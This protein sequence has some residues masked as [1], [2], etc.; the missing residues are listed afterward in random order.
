MSFL[1]L[2]SFD[3]Y[4]SLASKYEGAGASC[5]IV[6]GFA[7][8]GL[9][10]VNIQGGFNFLKVVRQTQDVLVATMYNANGSSGACC[11]LGNEGNSDPQGVC[12]N[13]DINGDGSISAKRGTSAGNLLLGTSA[14]GVYKFGVYNSVALR[15]TIGVAARVRIYCNGVLV[16]D[17]NGVTTVNNHNP[18][19]T[20]ID[21]VSWDGGLVTVF[22][23]DVYAL[24]CTDAIH[25]TYLGALRMYYGVPTADAAVQF[26]PSI[27]PP[28]YQQVNEVP[29]N[30]NTIFNS[31]DTVGQADQYV[32][33]F[34]GSIPPVSTLFCVQHCL[35]MEVA[36]GSRQVTSDIGG[37]LNANPVAL[38]G[39]YKIDAFQYDLNPVTGLA[40]TA[41]DFPV[42]AG[43]AVTG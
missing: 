23:D 16:L 20:Y 33:P 37:V 11:S 25:N 10:C 14:P 7:R 30:E 8:T 43:P 42:Q 27:A 34:P 19:R 5:S 28:N 31:S 24:D 41:A 26:T 12:V 4:T 22:H 9:Q 6:Q 38:A 18:A 29:P 39:G 40:W 36:N 1:W 21:A 17:L 15:A 32:Y 13:A 3:H 2:D 35:D